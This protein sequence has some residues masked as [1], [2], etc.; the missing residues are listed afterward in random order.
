MIGY[1]HRV[2]AI[3][4]AFVGVSFPFFMW[5]EGY[6]LLLVGATSTLPFLG[7]YL[8]WRVWQSMRADGMFA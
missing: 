6:H 1:V 8:S 3:V 5:F 7:P 2:I 4:P